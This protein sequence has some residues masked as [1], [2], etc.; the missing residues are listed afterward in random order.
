MGKKILI[1][2]AV[3]IVAAI[4]SVVIGGNAAAGAVAPKPVV[5]RVGVT[6]IIQIARVHCW[7][8]GRLIVC[9]VPR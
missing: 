5:S 6:Q 4:A 9:G 2:V 7:Q 8:V 3:A 1:G